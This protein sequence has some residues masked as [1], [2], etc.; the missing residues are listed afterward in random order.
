MQQI[1]VLFF[2]TFWDFF[3]NIFHLQLVE[4]TKSPQI[5]KDDYMCLPALARERTKNNKN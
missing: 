2:G 5:Q 3:L 1:Q 4:Y